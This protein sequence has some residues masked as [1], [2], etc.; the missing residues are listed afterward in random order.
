MK[1]T[2]EINLNEPEE[3]TENDLKTMYQNHCLYPKYIKS[4]GKY[5]PLRC[6]ECIRCIL[7][8]I[9]YW[10]Y[11]IINEIETDDTKQ[12][13]I[14]YINEKSINEL[15]QV[16]NKKKIEPTEYKL[17]N[18]I[19]TIAVRRFLEIWRK[20]T[21]T[22]VK[23]WFTTELTNSET[24]K[25]KIRGI[26]FNKNRKQIITSWKY[27]NVMFA[28]YIN[29]STIIKLLKYLSNTNPKTKY[30]KPIVLCS[31]KIGINTYKKSS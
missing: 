30:Y 24:N 10:E 13:V 16:A 14:M 8:N 3:I 21:G 22:S 26:I 23:H 9:K 27:G 28:D 5:I 29:I 4:K 7:Y 17:F 2:K 31:P 12:F 11:R 20:K 25:I 1:L 18:Q 15:K 19:A 6:G